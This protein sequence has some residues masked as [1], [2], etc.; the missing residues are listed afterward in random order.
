MAVDPICKMQVDPASAKYKY[1]YQGQT[2][3][4]CSQN[5]LNRFQSEPEKYPASS[6]EPEAAVQVNAK[7]EKLSRLD[8]SVRGMSCASCAQTISRSLRKVTGVDSAEVNFATG[9]ARVEYNP[10]Q[11][12]PEAM[13]RA[14]EDAG[15]GVIREEE[16]PENA[17]QRETHS[18]KIAKQRMLA[19]W[20]FTAPLVLLMLWEIISGKHAPYMDLMV[21]MLATPPVFWAGFETHRGAL[22]AA[23]H[24]EANMESLISLGTLAAYFTGV[25]AVLGFPIT[26][27]AEVGAMI[28]GI[29]LIGK[30]LE[31]RTMGRASQAIRKLLG[32]GA[33]TARIMVDGQEREVPIDRVKIGDVMVIRP[34]EKI[35]TDGEVIEGESSVDESLATGESMPV[36]KQPGDQVIGA[37]INQRGR[38][39]VRAT[40]VGNETF[41]AQMIRLVEEAQGSKVPIQEMADRVT[42]YFVP[43]VIVI[44]LVTFGLWLTFPEF[45]RGVITWAANFIPWVNP[46]LSNLS[47]AVF[48][49]VAVLVIAC[50]CALGL[51]TPTAL[52]VGSGLGAENGI[53]IRKGA[54]IQEMREVD[55]IVFD[56]TGTIT[57][58]KPK[59]TDIAAAPGY[60]NEE[61]IQLAASLSAASEHPLSSAITGYA[62]ENNVELLPVSD[63]ESLTGKGVK[64]VLAGKNILMG[65]IRLMQENKINYSGLQSEMDK[66]EGGGKTTIM[67]ASNGELAGILAVA[68]TLKPDSA[69]AI[70]EIKALGITPVMLT[71]DNR[72]T[73]E[74]IARQVDI[75]QVVAE[76]LPDQKVEQVKGLQMQGKK[77]ACVGDG[78][79][80]AP[81][82]AAAD[83]GLAVGTG[84]DIAIESADI[85]LV[86]GDLSSVVA[87]IKLSQATFA[88]IEQNLF[89]AFFYNT[90]AIPIAMLGLLHPAIAEAAMAASS[91]NVVANSLRLK[92]VR[93]RP[94]RG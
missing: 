18:L 46:D 92:R 22:K 49:M 76:V 10:R 4:F 28:M 88:K 17:A 57:M 86:R 1:D 81:A 87:A 94:E 79:N 77:V 61:L 56:K 29:Y 12:K 93:I 7:K 73:A 48:A 25:A 82:L 83:V 8:I 9:K 58:G 30:Y 13:Y 89:W 19:A 42:G 50:P 21:L 70:G 45:F 35:P 23:G 36:A 78:I 71:G 51:A 26:S 44:A 24:L 38:L 54:A 90:V 55:T 59:L 60:Q 64:G 47:L 5:C 39:L 65:S 20:V 37:T 15:Y 6:V 63:F 31:T 34:G 75:S 72:R 66:L 33:K 85:T 74:A 16:S 84:T 2:Y 43:V 91:I 27:Y 32:M 52:M 40:K 53:F 14:I 68:D 11:V 80:D 41:L 69:Q 67:V 3:Y 62:K